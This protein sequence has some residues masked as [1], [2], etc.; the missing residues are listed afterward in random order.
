MFFGGV[1]GGSMETRFGRSFQEVFDGRKSCDDLV[2]NRAVKR[3]E[4]FAA[5]LHFLDGHPRDFF[6]FE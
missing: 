6:F 5:L 4:F 3:S 1:L 2:D